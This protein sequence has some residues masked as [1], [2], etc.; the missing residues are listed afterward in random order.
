MLTFMQHQ[1]HFMLEY[2]RGQCMPVD[3]AH[4]GLWKWLWIICRVALLKASCQSQFAPNPK[5]KNVCPFLL[6]QKFTRLRWQ[7]AFE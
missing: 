2:K 4:L 6:P 7:A 5:A 3:H 1:V